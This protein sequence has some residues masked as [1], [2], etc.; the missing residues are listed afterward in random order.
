MALL[1]GIYP[2][3]TPTSEENTSAV[4]ISQGGMI[5]I[6]GLSVAPAP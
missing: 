6:L 1:A 2:A 5:D 4:I 3:I